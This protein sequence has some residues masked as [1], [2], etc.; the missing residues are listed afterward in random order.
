MRDTNIMN[1]NNIYFSSVARELE[2]VQKSSIQFSPIFLD[3]STVKNQISRFGDIHASEILR[4]QECSRSLGSVSENS[5]SFLRNPV[6][7]CCSSN[8]TVL[9]SYAASCRQAMA[10]MNRGRRE[11]VMKEVQ[12]ATVW[13]CGVWW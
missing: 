3:I 10:A 6:S 11:I 5:T 7:S 2:I 8:G 9:D 1:K 13:Q 12:L 4:L